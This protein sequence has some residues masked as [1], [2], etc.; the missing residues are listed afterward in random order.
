MSQT[1]IRECPKQS[2]NNLRLSR[3]ILQRNLLITGHHLKRGDIKGTP[4][5]ESS[6]RKLNFRGREE[7]GRFHGSS[8]EIFRVRGGGKEAEGGGRR[9]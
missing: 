7:E 5:K 8:Q 4:I 9:W 6:A 1:K 3:E 2:P